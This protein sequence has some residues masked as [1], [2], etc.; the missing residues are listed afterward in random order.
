MVKLLGHFSREI[1]LIL[2]W[3]FSIGVIFLIVYMTD[4]KEK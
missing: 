2:S 4:L 3:C 1:Y